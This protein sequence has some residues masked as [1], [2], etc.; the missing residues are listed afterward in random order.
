MIFSFS[1][2]AQ[3]VALTIKLTNQ[4]KEPLAFASVE[5]IN[6]LDSTIITQAADSN[7]ISLF[8]LVK[9]GQYIVKITAVNYQ[10]IEKGI[11][12][13][14]SKTFFTF[15]AAPLGKTLETAIIFSKKPLMRQEDDKTIVDPE[16]LVASSTNGYEVI[17]KTPGLFVDQDGNIFISSL[18]PAT[19]QI[20]SR[21][22]KMSAG[23]IA[24]MLKSLP[25]NSILKIEIVRTHL[26]NM[27]HQVV[28]V[29]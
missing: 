4:K 26:Q 19:V 21:N 18:T 12:V 28:V 23:D 10:T 20:N 2:L 16:N 14:G 17:E 5:L 1:V 7:G 25:A 29:W 15:T 27:M 6:R 3:N 11:A 22:M 9:E 13:T 24:T 8:N